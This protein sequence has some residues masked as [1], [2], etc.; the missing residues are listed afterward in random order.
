MKPKKKKR[1]E[2]PAIE[3]ESVIETS[4]LA[5]GKCVPGGPIGS[6]LPACQQAQSTS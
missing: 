4:T 3:T 5:C 6:G 1:Y 2:P